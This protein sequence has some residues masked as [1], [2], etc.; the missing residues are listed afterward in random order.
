MKR[1]IHV[2]R[3]SMYDEDR[4]DLT[5]ARVTEDQ[6]NRLRNRGRAGDPVTSSGAGR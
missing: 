2:D 4:P 1:R 5:K 6:A 3:A